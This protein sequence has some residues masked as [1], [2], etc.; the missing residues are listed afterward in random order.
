MCWL[1]KDLLKS[2][3]EIIKTPISDGGTNLWLYASKTK[4]LSS[5]YI[6]LRVKVIE[7]TESGN[8]F[9]TGKKTLIEQEKQEPKE[10]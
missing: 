3:S 7:I 2:S 8:V 10:G 5:T 6:D 9:A 1:K 4:N